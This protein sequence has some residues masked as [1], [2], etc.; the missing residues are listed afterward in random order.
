[1]AGS[2]WNE[3]PAQIGIPGRVSPECAFQ[4][5]ALPE[6]CNRTPYFSTLHEPE[7]DCISKGKARVHHEFGCKVS[8]AIT[9]DE[10]FVV[11]MRSFAGNPYDGHTLNE[12]PEQ[13]TILTDQSPD[14]AAV[15]RGYLGHGETKTRV[16]I[17]G[18]RRGRP[19]PN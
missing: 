18:T 5:C 2:D 11:G 6:D 7:A 1:V 17:S 14:L 16:L 15:D 8:R 3:W 13:V 10:G 9:L 4:W 12:A 19:P